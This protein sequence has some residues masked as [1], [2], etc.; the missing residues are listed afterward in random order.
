[1]CE[2]ERSLTKKTKKKPTNY[3]L[4]AI[5]YVKNHIQVKPT[6]PLKSVEEHEAITENSCLADTVWRKTGTY[7]LLR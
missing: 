2:R 6:V 4:N 7:Y 1:M 3:L 5:V